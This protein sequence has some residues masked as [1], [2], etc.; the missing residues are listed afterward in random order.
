M[1]NTESYKSYIKSPRRS[2][3]HTTYFHSYDHFF[4]KYRNKDITFVE[5]GILDGGSLFMWRD[6]FGPDARIIGVDLNP[7]AKKWESE[8]F[9]I[10]IGSQSD[11]NFWSQ[12]VNLVGTIDVVLDDGGH[13][14]KQQITTTECLIEYINDG[15]IILIE[16]THT[17]YMKGFGKRRNSFINYAKDRIDAINYRFSAL[18]GSRSENRI[19]SIEIVESMVGFKV[20]KKATE[21]PSNP[22]SNSGEAERAEDYR[23]ESFDNALIFRWLKRK[24]RSFLRNISNRT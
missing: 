18:D 8:G 23:Y 14:Y 7:N 4:H 12:F 20:N 1:E 9:E 10:F 19:W 17:S 15:G 2:I 24:I 22:T 16:D 21:L 5:I 6:Y 13:T 3:K 11:E